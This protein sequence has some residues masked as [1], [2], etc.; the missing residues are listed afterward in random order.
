MQDLLSQCLTDF[1]CRLSLVVLDVETLPAIAV[2]KPACE[3]M[4]AVPMAAGVPAELAVAPLLLQLDVPAVCAPDIACDL[5]P[6]ASD[7]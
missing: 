7:A 1:D 2:Q 6:H 4:A 3:H 5:E